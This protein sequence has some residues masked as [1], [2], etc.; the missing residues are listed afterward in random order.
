MPAL[1]LFG[2]GVSPTDPG[3]SCSGGVSF[4]GVDGSPN[5][6]RRFDLS[7]YGGTLYLLCAFCSSSA[8]FPVWLSFSSFGV[9]SVSCEALVV[10]LD[11]DN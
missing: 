5:S 8:C 11:S 10:L 1:V 6:T 9:V 7:W 3:A 4:I 2:G